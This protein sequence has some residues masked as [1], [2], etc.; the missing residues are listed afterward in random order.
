MTSVQRILNRLLIA[1]QALPS[2]RL[3]CQ[4]RLFLEFII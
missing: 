1:P 4:S 2:L 3:Y